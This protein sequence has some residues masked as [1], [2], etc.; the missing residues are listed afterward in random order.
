MSG[1]LQGQVWF[2]DVRGSE[3]DVLLAMADHGD[4]DGTR[5]FPSVD[6]LS[7]KVG[8]SRRQVQRIVSGLREK[9]AL[10][11]VREATRYE[12]THYRMELDALPAKPK[13][14]P[15]N[16]DDV[17]VTPADSRG[18]KSPPSGVTDPAA[19]GDVQMSPEPSGEPS[20]KPSTSNRRARERSDPWA[21][22][23]EEMHEVGEMLLV[24]KR[25]VGG[26]LVTADE[27]GIAASGLSEFNRQLGSSYQLGPW[28]TEIVM[29]ERDVPQYDSAAHVRLVQSAFRL[30]WWE[31]RGDTRRPKP[32]V[33]WGPKSFGE[34]IEQATHEASARRQLEQDSD[35]TTKVYGGVPWSALPAREQMN[36]R[37]SVSMG[38]RPW[39]ERSVPAPPAGQSVGMGPLRALDGQPRSWTASTFGLEDEP[40]AASAAA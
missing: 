32:G 38:L 14:E 27:M 37:E 9:G 30:R 5:I 29:R 16:R 35:P 24:Q 20:E 39:E 11:V 2:R 23:T 26:R 17:D 19:R 4:D 28:F 31:R 10:I 21:F 25:K 18:D 13:Y 3:R 33:V 36:V 15:K 40:P 8:I 12:P 1:Y 22:S 6:Y 34:A 7:W